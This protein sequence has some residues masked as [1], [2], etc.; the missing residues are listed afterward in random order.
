MYISDWTDI[1]YF[2]IQM[3]N[4][5]IRFL[6]ISHTQYQMFDKII[7]SLIQLIIKSII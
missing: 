1:L 3:L 4:I 5:N 7:F 6:R 2:L